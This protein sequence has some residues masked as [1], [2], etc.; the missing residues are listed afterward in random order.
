LCVWLDASYGLTM[1]PMVSLCFLWS[2]YASYGVW[3]DASY[4]LTMLPMVSLASY[5]LTMLPM[6]CGSMLPM[7][8]LVDSRYEGECKLPSPPAAALLLLQGR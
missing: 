3:L 7:V 8:S 2:H 1:L 4:G 6:V 5:G